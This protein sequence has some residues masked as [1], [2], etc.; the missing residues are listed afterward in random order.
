VVI[1]HVAP[2]LMMLRERLFSPLGRAVNAVASAAIANVKCGARFTMAIIC[3][4][5][6][7]IEIL[8]PILRLERK[9]LL[10]SLQVSTVCATSSGMVG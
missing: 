4:S 9:N 5:W 2:A 3:K 6:C 10:T 8:Q 1:H 7:G